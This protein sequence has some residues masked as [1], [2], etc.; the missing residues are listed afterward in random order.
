MIPEKLALNQ[1][2]VATYPRRNA[3]AL[4]ALDGKAPSDLSIG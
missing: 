3:N 1:C 2:G 4:Q